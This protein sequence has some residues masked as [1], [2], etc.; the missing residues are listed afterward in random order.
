[1]REIYNKYQKYFSSEAK[2]SQEKIVKDITQ[3]HAMLR[4]RMDEQLRLVM[5]NCQPVLSEEENAW[6][7]KLEELSDKIAG[8]S[9]YASR[10]DH[11]SS[12]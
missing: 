3:R 2:Q 11:V 6:I 8:S 1:M 12:E 7:K 4:L 9:G 10:I 5:L